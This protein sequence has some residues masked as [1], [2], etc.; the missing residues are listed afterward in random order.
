[1][2]P[3]VEKGSHVPKYHLCRVSVIDCSTNVSLREIYQINN[4]DV[5]TYKE[6]GS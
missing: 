4:P 2:K 3:K 1:M 5:Q 6:S